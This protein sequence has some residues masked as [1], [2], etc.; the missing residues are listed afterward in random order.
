MSEWERRNADTLADAIGKQIRN[1][2][3]LVEENALLL[4]IQEAVDTAANSVSTTPGELNKQRANV[5]TICRRSKLYE[6]DVAEG[7]SPT[8]AFVFA[9]TTNFGGL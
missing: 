3:E 7:W 2:P 1:H 6:C 4:V 9:N 5:C 8:C